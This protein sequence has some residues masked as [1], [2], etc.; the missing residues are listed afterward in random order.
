MTAPAQ[1][2]AGAASLAGPPGAAR[3]KNV[4]EA[5]R[6]F[7]ALLIGQMLKGAWGD[8]DGGWLGSGEDPGSATAMELAE[9]QFAQA[10]A[11]KGGLGLSA[12][13]ASSL[14]RGEPAPAAHS[15]APPPGPQ[16]PRR[17]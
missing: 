15:P 1:L 9:E 5:A 11:Q 3:P 2:H 14:S 12:Q 8:E 13:I 4:A 10:L 17:P 16:I 6:Q 7:E